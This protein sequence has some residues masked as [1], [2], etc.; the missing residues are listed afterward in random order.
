LIPSQHRTKVGETLTNKIK[1]RNLLI[2][3]F[4][5]QSERVRDPPFSSKQLMILTFPVFFRAIIPAMNKVF[6]FKKK[7]KKNFTVFTKSGL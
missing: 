7:K 2:N 4:Y 3:P 5:R 1:V 6:Y